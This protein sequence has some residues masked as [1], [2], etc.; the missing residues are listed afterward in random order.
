MKFDSKKVEDG[1]RMIIEGIGD[2]PKRD[3]VLPSAP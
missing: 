2:D 3:G 1:M